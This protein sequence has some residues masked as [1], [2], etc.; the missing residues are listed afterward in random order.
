MNNAIISCERDAFRHIG[1]ANEK[2]ASTMP[3]IV[4]ALYSV[5]GE[6][7]DIRHFCSPA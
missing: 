5:G 6:Q 1:F 2:S 3:V 7:E 4:K